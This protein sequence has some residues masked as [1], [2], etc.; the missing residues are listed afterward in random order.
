MLLYCCV[1]TLVVRFAYMFYLYL[2]AGYLHTT[3]NLQS[4]FPLFH[5]KN[6]SRFDILA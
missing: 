3:S 1:T 4:V 6:V 5:G 2:H